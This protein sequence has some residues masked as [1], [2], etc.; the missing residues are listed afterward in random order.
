MI[1]D[2]EKNE[3]DTKDLLSVYICHSGGGEWK[4]TLEANSFD[5][6]LV[7]RAWNGNLLIVDQN[8]SSTILIWDHEM[9]HSCIDEFPFSGNLIKYSASLMFSVAQTIYNTLTVRLMYQAGIS[10]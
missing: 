4:K 2:C 1:K 8:S 3:E 7:I 10:G 9:F 5:L 6:P